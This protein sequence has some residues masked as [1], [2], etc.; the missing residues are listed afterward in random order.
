MPEIHLRQPGLTYSACGSK[1][2]ERIQKFK[3]TGDSWYFYQNKLGKACYRHHMTYEDFKDLP[4]RTASGNVL[5][6]KAFNAAKV[7]KC[8]GYQRAL[9]LMVYKFFDKKSSGTNTSA[10]CKNKFAGGTV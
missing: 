7:P 1:N 3:E 8:D 9:A 4:T 5:R 6:D 2:K 10:T